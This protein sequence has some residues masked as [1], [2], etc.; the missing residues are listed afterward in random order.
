MTRD[1]FCCVLASFV[2]QRNS[3]LFKISAS[4]GAGLFLKYSYNFAN[5]SL[6]ILIKFIVKKKECNAAACFCHVDNLCPLKN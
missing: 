3:S 2:V 5:F 6:D 1:V 4:R